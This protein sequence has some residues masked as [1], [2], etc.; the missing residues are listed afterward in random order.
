MTVNIQDLGNINAGI[1]AAIRGAE[2]FQGWTIERGVFVNDSPDLTPW[3]GIY[4]REV[5]YETLNLG[6][7]TPTAW[8]GIATMAVVLQRSGYDGTAVEN[9]LEDDIKQALLVVLTSGF[10]QDFVDRVINVRVTYNYEDE[11]EDSFNFQSA[12]IEITLEVANG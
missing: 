9:E 10:V 1:E 12:F 2:Y 6:Q 7:N 11:R 8:E 3:C 5:T 4:R